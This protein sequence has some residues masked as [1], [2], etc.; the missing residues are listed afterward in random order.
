LSYNSLPTYFHHYRASLSTE[1]AL[2]CTPR[3]C[4]PNLHPLFSLTLSFQLKSFFPLPLY[5]FFFFLPN[6]II[7]FSSAV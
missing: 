4:H 1:T 5:L 3:S 7:V 6:C 2:Y